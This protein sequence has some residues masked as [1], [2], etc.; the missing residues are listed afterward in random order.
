MKQKQVRLLSFSYLSVPLVTTLLYKPAF[1]GAWWGCRASSSS[2][3]CPTQGKKHGPSSHTLKDLLLLSSVPS[4][5][6]RAAAE[7]T[8]DQEVWLALMPE[9]VPPAEHL[10]CQGPSDQ[11]TAPAQGQCRC[12]MLAWAKRHIQAGLCRSLSNSSQHL[13]SAKAKTFSFPHSCKSRRSHLL[14]SSKARRISMCSS[15]AAK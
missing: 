11:S 3:R 12:N 7:V 5:L 15:L 13:C 14:Y 10:L 1:T 6:S 9:V 2:Q 4:L 8:L